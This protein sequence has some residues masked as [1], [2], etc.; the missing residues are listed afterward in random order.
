MSKK[1]NVAV[2][3]ASSAI[4]IVYQQLRGSSDLNVYCISNLHDIEDSYSS[5][6]E[7]LFLLLKPR[8]KELDY[9]L[10]DN[11]KFNKKS[12]RKNLNFK[13]IQKN[14]FVQRTCLHIM[15]QKG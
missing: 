11:P 15:H 5:M 14:K 12:L 13:N 10:L 4:D 3:G 9:L 2:V 6:R 1:L 7:M 8:K